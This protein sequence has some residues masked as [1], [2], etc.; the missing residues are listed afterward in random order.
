MIYVESVA[1]SLQSILFP[2]EPFFP[3]LFIRQDVNPGHVY[4]TLLYVARS[5]YYV[6]F[7]VTL[8][9]NSIVYSVLLLT[10]SWAL[11]RWV[12]RMS[13]MGPPLMTQFNDVMP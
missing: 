8:Y 9:C 11:E 12:T 5:V 2:P 6:V 10:I 1:Y 3:V 4:I 7:N 13:I